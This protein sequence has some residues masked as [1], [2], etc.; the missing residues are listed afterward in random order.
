MYALHLLTQVHDISRVVTYLIQAV[1]AEVGVD[2]KADSRYDYH[3]GGFP[4]ICSLVD[5]R[6]GAFLDLYSCCT[7]SE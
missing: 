3:V 1:V 2:R 4:G 7:G 5:L 6:L